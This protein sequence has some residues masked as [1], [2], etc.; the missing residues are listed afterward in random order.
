MTGLEE[1]A[2]NG[3]PWAMVGFAVLAVLTG[4]LSPRRV[5]EDLREELAYERNRS[6]E[7]DATVRDL[8]IE[9]SRLAVALTNAA[10]T[11]PPPGLSTENVESVG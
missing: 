4:R 9:A 6:R 8:V 7:L 11:N 5:V 3:G 1:V 2:A 10:V